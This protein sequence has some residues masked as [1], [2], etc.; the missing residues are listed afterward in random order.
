MILGLLL[1]YYLHLSIRT[2]F[3]SYLVLPLALLISTLWLFPPNKR[4]GDQRALSEGEV[5]INASV[6]LLKPTSWLDSS[7]PLKHIF[8][9]TKMYGS[10]KGPSVLY[11]ID[12]F[13]AACFNYTNYLWT[14]LSV[15]VLHGN[16]FLLNLILNSLCAIVG[17]AVAIS[18]NRWRRV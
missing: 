18:I 16:F 2:M 9:L 8:L 17:L 14:F 5:E 15:T 7:M 13:L 10:E 3:L 1:N 11:G 4:D 6:P 12:A